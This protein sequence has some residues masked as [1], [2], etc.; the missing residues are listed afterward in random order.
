MYQNLRYNLIFRCT[1]TYDIATASITTQKNCFLIVLNELNIA[2]IP[3]KQLR[4]YPTPACNR[5]QSC[6]LFKVDLIL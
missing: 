4:C 6:S 1:E 5:K 2:E 3:S